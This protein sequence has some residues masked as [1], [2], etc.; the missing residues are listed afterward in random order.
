MRNLKSVI[1]KKASAEFI[2]T[3]A[4]VFFGCG[5][6]VIA[7]GQ[8]GFLGISLA[9]GFTLTMLVYAIG[10][11]S[12]CHVNPAVTIAM[13]IAKKITPKD[14]GT[15][16]AAQ[17]LGGVFGA[18]LIASITGNMD[19]LGQNGYGNGSPA[20]YDI[21]AAFLT[22]VVL[23]AFFLMV[24]LGSGSTK[25]HPGFAGLAIGMALTVIH[26]VGIPITG[27]SVNP[28][29]SFGPALLAGGEALGQLWLFVVAP[30]IGAVLGTVMHHF[31]FVEGE[32]KTS[33]KKK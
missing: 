27:T 20:G 29:R 28:A 6:A 16:I 1:A 18:Y 2:G 8:V 3:A 31:A 30:V 12:G 13:L 17:L 7:G 33:R 32:A 15:Y 21:D 10:P 4:L 14:A 25:A 5:S 22:E 23:T 11:I 24:I 9:F 26:I 19:A